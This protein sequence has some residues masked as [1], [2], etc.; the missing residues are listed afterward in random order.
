MNDMAALPLQI[1][2]VS[3]FKQ[4]L[5]RV[6]ATTRALRNST[7]PFTT[8]HGY[9]II[10]LLPMV[11]VVAFTN[12]ASR[13]VTLVF[14]NV[15]GPK[16]PLDYGGYTCK[17]FA[18]LLPAMG[19]ISCGLSLLSIGDQLKV[20]LLTDKNILSEPKEVIDILTCVKNQ[21]VASLNQTV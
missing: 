19:E 5:A 14:S 11:L 12:F 9:K 18:F 4:A 6:Q 10:G 1:S 3:D 17:K 15:A 21:V 8:Y 16:Q 2:L 20:G 13:K 7:T